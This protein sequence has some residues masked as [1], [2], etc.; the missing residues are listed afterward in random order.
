M[1]DEFWAGR[2]FPWEFDPGPAAN[3]AWAELLAE[4]PN[5]RG[6]GVAWSGNEEFRWHFGPMFYR[7]RLDGGAA[8]V[9]I[10]G[11]EGAQDESL[12]HRSFT[13]GTGGR[14]QHVLNH[15]GI[16]H[17][18]LFLNTF[19]YPIFGQYD[20]GLRP[21]AQDPRS[22]IVL[23]RHKIFDLAASRHDLRLVIAVGTAA[24]ESV[25]TWVQSHGGDADP[26][27]LHEA[28]GDAIK[29][30]L[31][32]VG[33]LHPGSATSGTGPII[34]DF[35]AALG[36]IDAWIAADPGWLPVDSDGERQPAS[37][38]E[39]RNAPIPFRD[40]PFGAPWRLG[41]GTTTSNRRDDQVAI[42]LF[43]SDGRY[44]NDGVTL[45]YPALSGTSN[46]GYSDDPGDLP[47]E[48]PKQNFGEFDRGPSATFAKLLQGGRSAFPWPDFTTLGLPAHPSFGFGPIV[49]GRLT[50]PSIL[51]LADQA[52]HDDLFTARALTGEAGQRLQGFL[53]AAGID[54]RYAVL[55]TLPVNALGAPAA[56]VRAA[57]DDPKVQA[58]LREA[59]A[60]ADPRVV[61]AV[62]P[63]ATRIVDAV[64]PSNA[65]T[66]TMKAWG[67][68]ALTDWRRALH[69]LSSQTYTKDHAATFTWDG[70]RLQIPRA[71]LPYG[72]LRWQATSGNRAVQA[73]IG[74]SPSRDYFK[75]VMPP[76]AAKLAPAALST[77]EQKA[78]DEL[79]GDA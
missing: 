58:L 73:K 79:R 42:Q 46:E 69:D 72:T 36:R 66:I 30:G 37:A 19:V 38:F 4:T 74:G 48:P 15:L 31:R 3:G 52:S 57:V 55:R 1:W 16:T 12:A 11:Q 13:G 68:T 65:A 56:K 77:S 54:R 35:K 60:K 40:F 64:T 44:N 67:S 63:N 75:I 43:S 41:F 26:R 9:M 17:S 32:I 20:D 34:A 39:Y 53:D 62:G 8:K 23:H 21:L 5:Y 18:Y 7:G 25:A 71:D 6:I 10:V 45:T 49:R 76:W 61:L 14:M 33:V 28:D 24:K 47:Y 2:G 22:P 50:N 70:N 27:K 51:V 78:I 29:S 59:I